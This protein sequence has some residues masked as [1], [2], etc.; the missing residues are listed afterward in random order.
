MRMTI[1]D[2]PQQVKVIEALESKHNDP[3]SHRIVSKFDLSKPNYYFEVFHSDNPIRPFIDLDQKDNVS[4]TNEKEFW[5]IDKDILTKLEG[6]GLPILHAS[7]YQAEKWEK[8][9]GT[10]WKRVMTKKAPKLSYRI[11]DP[12]KMCENGKENKIYCMN[13]FQTQIKTCLGDE[14]F[15]MLSVDSSVYS[16]NWRKLSCVNTYK[17]PEQKD[18]IRK[19]TQPNKFKIEDTFLSSLSGNEKLVKSCFKTDK[20]PKKVIPKITKKETPNAYTTLDNEVIEVEKP[21]LSDVSKF[22][23][24]ADLINKQDLKDRNNWLK[25]T[26]S[27]I[28]LLGI[29]DYENYNKFCASCPNY[30]DLPNKIKYEEFYKGKDKQEQ[31]LGW[32]HIFSLAY[33]NNKDE[34][35]KL[36]KIYRVPFNI[37]TILKLK[38]TDEN[39]HADIDKQIEELED[40]DDLKPAVVKRKI[41]ELEK[42]KKEQQKEQTEKAYKKMKS[43]FELYHFKLMNP[44]SYCVIDDDGFHPYSKSKFSDAF[45]NIELNEKT[46][47][48]DMWFK[49]PAMKTY[50]KV[51]FIPYGMQC[52][53]ST[54]NLFDGLH[55]EKI[56][57]KE[58]KSFDF[59]LDNL[60]LNAGDDENA[61]QYLLKYSAYLVQ[62]TATLPEVSI[63]IKGKQGT[64][65][66]KYWENFGNK[67]LGKRYLL[68]SSNP[69]DIIGKFN[70][71]INKLLIIMEETEGKDTFMANSQIKTL[72]TQPTKYFEGKGKD[73]I[74]VRN[75][76]RYIFISNNQ[77]PIKIEQTDRRFQVCECSDRHFQ[78]REFFSKVQNEW[79]DEVCVRGFYDY[80]M[81][82]DL[83]N[84]DPA[85]DRVITE[86]YLDLQSATI[87]PLVRFLENQ[88]YYY[89]SCR[90]FNK[91]TEYGYSNDLVEKYTATQ[92]FNKYL[93]FLQENNMKTEHISSTNFG[94]E[95]I[96]YDGITKKH[97]KF[98]N[99]YE[100]KWEEVYEKLVEKKMITAID[101][102][103]DNHADLENEIQKTENTIHTYIQE[104]KKEEESEYESEY[105][106]YEAA[107]I[108]EDEYKA[109]LEWKN[110]K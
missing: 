99:Q 58:K 41:K 24:Y 63:V 98:G 4:F 34:K 78:D 38:K 29:S 36:D 107:S 109:F 54:Y 57:T 22:W 12:N 51:D 49:D 19:L 1:S 86:A 79:N 55:I 6:L 17:H 108:D 89:N 7:H 85:R 33:E 101:D 56:R 15:G 23:D 20:P 14:L 103:E 52:P 27:H 45:E 3:T 10:E 71:N 37:W 5:K 95:I 93:G 72:I 26:L 11:T 90:E 87:S 50:N 80:L 74:E 62:N 60:R 53:S 81:D 76:G 77:T 68:Q 48:T 100:V 69:D 92:F 39:N 84:F 70:I 8:N 25:F 40:N 44:I 35:M 83:S 75:C 30:E 16:V 9:K 82:M 104:E 91:K 97:T 67:I 102:E 105:E 21:P 42:K 65:K 110:K 28:N 43:Y 66:T 31:K 73:K 96:K 2:T 47:F 46:K 106:E 18:R 32:K 13:E 61:Y 88:F 59:I 94:R 64:G